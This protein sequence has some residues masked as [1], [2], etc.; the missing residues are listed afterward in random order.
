[1]CASTLF[2]AGIANAT[3]AETERPLPLP[4]RTALLVDAL[5][6]TALTHDAAGGI[7]R[8]ATTGL[9]IQDCRG[10]PSEADRPL[11]VAHVE[12]LEDLRSGLETGLSCLAGKGPMGRLHPYHEYQAHR[13]LSLFESDQ[14]KTLRCVADAMFATAVA[15]SPGGR[16]KTDPLARQLSLVEHPG[17]VIDTYRLGGLLSR[18]HND[19]TFRSFFHLSD[20][21]IYE[22]RN[23]QPIR[24]ARLHRFENR[25]ALLFHEVVHWLGHEHGAI[26]PDVTHLY[27]TCCFGGSDYIDDASLN[28]RYQQTA[29]DILRDD[30][31]WSQG[32]SPYKQMRIW[33]YKGYDQLKKT[34]RSDFSR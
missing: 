16:D 6:T 4:E 15:T 20:E 2:A 19:E 1:L 12:L 29:C 8:L 25:P 33:H 7:S 13:L 9:Q 23:G 21:Q 28:R 31:L 17:V 30:E 18:K 11:P 5:E 10:Y 22:H 32:Y 14:P 34:M 26:Q 24:A 27:E 3:P